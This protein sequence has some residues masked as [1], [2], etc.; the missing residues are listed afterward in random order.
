MESATQ[1]TTKTATI[2]SPEEARCYRQMGGGEARLMVT[3][4]QTSGAWWMGRFS[5]DPGFMT[6]LHY[7][8]QS[9]EQMYVLEGVLSVYADDE[10]YELGPGTL[11]L[12]PHGKPHAQGNRSSKPVEFIGSGTPAGFENLFSAVDALMKRLKPGTPEFMAEIQEITRRCDMV[13]V[14]PP[15]E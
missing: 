13:I 7:H 11:A 10:W 4:E 15:P 5:E 3:G 14:G 8:P 6:P 9:D 12:L 1:K 2:I